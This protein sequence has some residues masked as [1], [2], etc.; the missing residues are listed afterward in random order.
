MNGKMKVQS[1]ASMLYLIVILLFVQQVFAQKVTRHLENVKIKLSFG[2]NSL[3]R[4]IRT[5][6]LINASPGLK[7]SNLAGKG[8]EKNDKVGEISV[9]DCGRGDI[10]EL[11]ADVSWPQPSEPLRKLFGWHDGNGMWQYLLENGS[12][13]QVVRLKED[14]WNKPDAPLL[15][16]QLNKEGTRGFTIGL[17]Q[18][19]SQRSMW[20][21][22][23][24]VFIT[25]ADHP[26]DFK[27]HLAS[28][29]GER[30]LDG[31]AKHPDA[32]LEVFNKLWPD[33]GN[34]LKWNVPWQTKY[35]GTTGHLTVITA[36]Y[37]SIYKFAVDRWGNVRPDFA[38]PHKFRLDLNWPGSQWKQ[39]R[40]INGLPVIITNLEKNGQLAEIEQFAT[41]LVDLSV[42]IRGYIPSVVLTK[43]SLSGKAGPFSF[44]ISLYNELRDHQVE[45]IKIKD[46]WAIADKRTHDILLLLETGKGINV[47]AGNAIANENGQQIELTISG[48]LL[49]GET[50]EFVAKLP[51]PAIAPAETTRLSQLEFF[52]SEKKTTDYWDQWIRKGSQFEVPE[53][54][55]NE[56]FRANIWHALTL[57]R[58]TLDIDGK[59]H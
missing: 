36:A 4:S 18:L 34:P 44:G 6:Q 25:L 8:I 40:I 49:E 57:P 14:P 53:K 46:S 11:I 9:L 20:L 50:R 39:Q 12:A 10:D 2:N 21:P 1:K 54:A 52:T 43:V 41:P 59:D 7:V 3:I 5:V 15:T 31:V 42:T 29:K 37:G 58:H 22:E 38:S 56:L 27:R 35:M 32:S 16:V 23:Q 48:S 45:A 28:L 13:G 33:I 26:A 51:S 55:V 19:I 17:E 47:S 24:D 30:I